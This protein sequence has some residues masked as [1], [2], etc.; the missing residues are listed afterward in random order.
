MNA[1]ESEVSIPD[2]LRFLNAAQ[3][4]DAKQQHQRID[5]IVAS[6]VS[7]VKQTQ[8]WVPALGLLIHIR[9]APFTAGMMPQFE[10]LFSMQLSPNFILKCGRQVGKS[11]NMAAKSIVMSAMIPYFQ[12]LFVTPQFEMT[13]RFSSNYVRPLLDFSPIADAVL[14]TSCEKSVLQKTMVNQAMMHFSYAYLDADRVRGIPADRCCIDEAQDINV[15]FIPEIV[16][17]MGRSDWK[18]MDLSGTP[19]TFDNAME[20]YWEKSS[21]AEWL[22]PCDVCSY[23]NNP[24]VDADGLKMIGDKTL[25]CAKCSTPLDSVNGYW[26]HMRPGAMTEFIGRHVPQFIMPYH[27]Q[28]KR[29]WRKIVAAKHGGISKRLFYNEILGESCD[30]GAKLVTETDLKTASSLPVKMEYHTAQRL[31]R[32]YMFRALGVDWGG[33]GE[34]SMSFTKLAVI[35][36]RADGRCDLL[37][38]ENLARFPDGGAEVARVVN[39]FNDYNCNALAHDTGGT[40]GMRDTMLAHVGFPMKHV[41][42]MSYITTWT[43]EVVNYHETTETVRR[44]YYSVDKTKSLI[45]TALCIK[46]GFLLFPKY[47]SCKHLLED[48]LALVEHKSETKRGSDIYLINRNPALSDDFAHAVNFAA[49]AAFHMNDAWP[50]LVDSVNDNFTATKESVDAVDP[51]SSK[52]SDWEKHDDDDIDVIE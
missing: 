41:V 21:M 36:M 23:I 9:G 13:R 47:E 17:T 1:Q 12:T 30:V 34:D 15:D 2:A 6:L 14:S 20:Y 45:L 4:F 19:K 37:W 8:S 50:N 31:T 7:V 49:M 10:A 28:N 42:P 22:I 3:T 43:R 5:D 48:F 27:Y 26:Q 18:I 51:G 11:S 44:P 38:G 25:I 40:A 35:G 39:V 46:H 29:N 16:Q 52:L 33:R 24:H 32:G